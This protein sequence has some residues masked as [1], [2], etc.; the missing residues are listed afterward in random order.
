M[1]SRFHKS[2]K[3]GPARVNFSKSGIGYSVGT[4][5]ARITKSAK[6]KTRATVG[7]PGTGLSYSKSIGS[8]KE[9]SSASKSKATAN[10]RKIK[11]ASYDSAEPVKKSMPLAI[12]L[13]VIALFITGGITFVGLIIVLAILDLFGVI[14]S[15]GLG[16]AVIG[17]S[18]IIGVLSAVIAFR[19]SMPE[20]SENA[21]AD[22]DGETSATTE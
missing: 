2:I 21:E 4:K 8:K 1:G 19:H 14:N 9:K 12:I 6:G 17:I 22:T 3:I 20:K 18:V 7:I 13:A 10:A 16:F 15:T 11:S 5:G